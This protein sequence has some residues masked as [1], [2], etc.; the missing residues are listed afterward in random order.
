[1]EWTLSTQYG[2]QVPKLWWLY[3]PLTKRGVSEMKIT[4]IGLD[5]AKL[6]FQVHGVDE[7]GK[8]AARKHWYPDST[9]VGANR[10][11]WVSAS[12][13]ILTCAH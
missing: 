2:I 8:V 12:V 10:I 5:L 4:T 9:P 13:A 1:M 3:L 6:L 7:R 11:C